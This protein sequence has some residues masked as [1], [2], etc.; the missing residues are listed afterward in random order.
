MSVRSSLPADLACLLLQM[1]AMDARCKDLHETGQA[2]AQRHAPLDVFVVREVGVPGHEELAMVAVAAGGVRIVNRGLLRELNITRPVFDSVAAREEA[3][4]RRREEAYRDHR[5]RATIA[6][7]TA[8]LV[9]DGLATGST[10]L[11]AV[12]AL[13]AQLPGRIV[14]AVPISAASTCEAMAAQVD[15][16]VCAVTPAPFVAVGTWYQ[17][18][19]QTTDDEVRTLLSA[20]ARERASEAGEQNHA[21]PPGH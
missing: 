4:L 3:E 20:A 2:L 6:G 10:M 16:I 5:E 7:R 9:D 18:F 19:S 11:A 17:D 21:D 15:E 14:V 8:I 12:A 1:I 13:R